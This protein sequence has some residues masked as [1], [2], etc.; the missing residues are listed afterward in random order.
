M[1]DTVTTWTVRY[2]A[3]T[4]PRDHY[5]TFPGPAPRRRVRV[6][7]MV[8]PPR[9]ALPGRHAAARSLRESVGVKSGQD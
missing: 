7:G 9:P 5:R 3:P 1:P 4:M 6:R 2:R 8:A